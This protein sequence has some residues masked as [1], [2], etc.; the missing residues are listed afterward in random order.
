MPGK[1]RSKPRE[2]RRGKK[3]RIF[4]L[5]KTASEADG[6]MCKF[7]HLAV[8][9]E[10]G[11]DLKIEYVSSNNLDK[12]TID[13]VFCLLKCNMK[14]AYEESDWGWSDTAKRDELTDES[15]RYLLA[16]DANEKIIGFSHFRF[17]IEE[18]YPILYCYELQIDPEFQRKGL[19]QHI[20]N[21]LFVIAHNFRLVKIVLTVFKHNIA[22][23]NFYMKSMAFRHDETCPKEEE[24]KCYVILS[25]F[26]D[27]NEI[28]R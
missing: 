19:G 10:Y 11:L 15:A 28:N 12:K 14:R 21:V 18:S 1:H 8:Y 5:V 16:K 7:P 24:G 3:A 27:M 9:K 2:T 17:D 13:E 6:L 22:G 20:M 25:K 23:L 4:A 26:V